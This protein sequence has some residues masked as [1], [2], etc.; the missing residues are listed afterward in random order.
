MARGYETFLPLHRCR[1]YWSDRIKELDCP[2]FPGYLFCRVPTTNWL[3]ILQ[4]IGVAEIV[5]TG[6]TPVPVD[7]EEFVAVRTLVQSGTSVEPWTFPAIGSAVRIVHGPLSGLH[8]VV[9]ET[10]SRY[11][12]VV[13]LTMLR[14]AVSAEIDSACIERIE[15]PVA[16]VGAPTVLPRRRAV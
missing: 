16:T 4:T 1:R 13:S 11:R 5:G 15:Q 14:R 8:G 2:L 9:I 3:P 12:I 7:A 10:K 6:R